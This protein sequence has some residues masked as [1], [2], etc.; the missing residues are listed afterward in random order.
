MSVI[1]FD[2]DL[3]GTY[4]GDVLDTVIVHHESFEQA[5]FPI[6]HMLNV[7]AD[8]LGWPKPWIELRSQEN[9]EA[10]ALIQYEKDSDGYWVK[11]SVIGKIPEQHC[12]VDLYLLDHRPN[13]SIDA[14][15]SDV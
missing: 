12:R 14:F 5:S 2:V 3:T 11:Q 10:L 15:L 7:A 4:E 13:R 9:G 6:T 8:E 1:V